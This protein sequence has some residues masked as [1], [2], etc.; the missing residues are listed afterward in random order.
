MLKHRGVYEFVQ[1]G[2]PYPNI[3]GSN[4]SRSP[5]PTK[6][7]LSVV[8]AIISVGNNPRCQ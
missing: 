3:V 2:I 4:A 1:Q 7:K 5:S 8:M 6:V